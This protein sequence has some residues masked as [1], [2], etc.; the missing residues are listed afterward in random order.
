MGSEGLRSDGR[1]VAAGRIEIEKRKKT[2]QFRTRAAH[3]NVSA[4][5]LPCRGSSWRGK[6]RSGSGHCAGNF[7]YPYP[8]PAVESVWRLS[9]LKILFNTH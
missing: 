2:R 9:R 7:F 6:I 3:F 4:V 5:T 1:L 8:Y